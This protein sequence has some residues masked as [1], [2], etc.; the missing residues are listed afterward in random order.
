ML[1]FLRWK[2]NNC[3]YIFYFIE[4]FFV[5]YLSMVPLILKSTVYFAVRYKFYTNQ[6]VVRRN[7]LFPVLNK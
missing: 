1:F 3:I 5:A 7:S 4:L 2:I 6:L